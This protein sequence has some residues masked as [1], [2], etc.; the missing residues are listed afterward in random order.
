MNVKMNYGGYNSRRYMKPWGAK[1]TFDGAKPVY[2]FRAGSYLGDDGG[3]I[4]VIVCEPG[5]IIATGQKDTRNIRNS[6]N[7]W[8]LV[9]EDGSTKETDKI[10]AYEHWEQ[11]QIDS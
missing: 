10:A 2:D 6:K 11:L 8:Y 4:V 9:A 5:D 1:I 7:V 3:G